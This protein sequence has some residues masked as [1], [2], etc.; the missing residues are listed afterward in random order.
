MDS[1]WFD[2]VLLPTAYLAG[3][4]NFSI[5]LFR[6]LGKGDPRKGFSGNPGT[7]NIYRQA[8]IYWAATVLLLDVGRAVG[9]AIAALEFLKYEFVP[10]AGFALILGNRFPCFHG[11]KG[12]KG[13]ANYLGF[14]AVIT[15]LAAG[16]SAL[17][18]VIVNSMVPKP[19]IASFFMILVLA[20]GS[21]SVIGN[22]PVS[23][24]GTIVTAL[25]IYANHKSNIVEIF[26]SKESR[27]NE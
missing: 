17:V 27:K 22:D 20:A 9:V 18:W 1:M 8:G 10:W 11:F 4:I 6:I 13:V 15:A 2:I 16:I 25:L 5:L 26:K 19:F 12:G 23:I 14:T 21:L 24:T 7:T 3:S